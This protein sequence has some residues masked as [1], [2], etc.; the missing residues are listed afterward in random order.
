MNGVFGADERVNMKDMLSWDTE[1]GHRLEKPNVY[2]MQI[3]KKYK[4]RMK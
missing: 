3:I 2:Y 1:K 4:E